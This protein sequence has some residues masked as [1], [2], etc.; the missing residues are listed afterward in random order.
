MTLSPAGLVEWP[1]PTVGTSTFIA[2]VSD[3]AGASVSQTF[4]VD[5]TAALIPVPELA[6]QTQAQA[7]SQLDLL[8]LTVGTITLDY[9]PTAPSGTVIG[10]T[11]TP[12]TLV[13]S[14]SPVDLVIS[15]GPAP[16]SVP[17]L[18]G[19]G[20]NQALAAVQAIHL[21]AGTITESPSDTVPAGKVISQNPSAGAQ[22]P[23]GSQVDLVVSIGPAGGGG[24]PPDPADVAPP[25]DPTIATKVYDGS[26]FLYTGSH[27]IQTGVV[28]GTI[29]PTRAS[30][31]RGQVL[32]KQNNPLPGV[33]LT[34]LNHP[35]Y[36][37]T[38]SRADGMFD[39]AVN[40]GGLLTVN[41]RKN[42][43]LSAQRQV[44]ALWQDYALTPD[45]VLIPVDSQVTTLDL[46]A[47]APMLVARGSVRTDADGSRQATLLFPQETQAEMVMPDGSRSRP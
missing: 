28:L 7:T 30:V 42:G 20:K 15:Q 8:H 35:E 11:P 39:M 16:V 5:T 34:V 6:G 17:D 43:Y 21:T 22:L 26:Q 37:Q 18:V 23:A 1:A 19:Q 2:Q 10:Q 13:G 29:D 9:H 41:Y 12:A 3:S 25:V 33:T 36:G 46:T 38:L 40:G 14:G 31:I 24:L 4:T 47:A 45:V 44:N 32:D 27:P